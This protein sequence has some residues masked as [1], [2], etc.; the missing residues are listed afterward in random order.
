[1]RTL[2]AGFLAALVLAAGCATT[3]EFRRQELLA[4]RVKQYGKLI[5]W[6]EFEGA[7]LYLTEDAPG[8]RTPPPKEVRVVDY[9]V[10]QLILTEAGRQAGQ[11]VEITYFSVN[12]PKVRTVTDLQKWEFDVE[13][14]E[15]FL[16]SGFPE[17][18]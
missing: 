17:F 15:W 18:K 8:R 16:K 2:C 7:Q 12:N 13:R 11:V 4:E 5:R 1:M 6:S 10:K 14:N 3:F 9:E